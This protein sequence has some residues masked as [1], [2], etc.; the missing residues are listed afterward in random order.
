MAGFPCYCCRTTGRG[1]RG[2]IMNVA[3]WKSISE[4]IGGAKVSDAKAGSN[5]QSG[6][7][8]TNL[9]AVSLM[10]PR[11]PFPK[12][13]LNN[14]L[15]AVG[16]LV[17]ESPFKAYTTKAL[18]E[19]MRNAGGKRDKHFIQNVV[20]AREFCRAVT[21]LL[22]SSY[23]GSVLGRWLVACCKFDFH[24]LG[25]SSLTRWRIGARRHRAWC[26]SARRHGA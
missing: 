7:C 17:L 20:C 24:R 16:F 11:Q 21:S 8:T 3:I 25:L 5:V 23:A 2:G 22:G 10:S 26:H 15:N 12:R 9:P 4:Q 14:L 19:S 13:L 1:V 18:V 6:R